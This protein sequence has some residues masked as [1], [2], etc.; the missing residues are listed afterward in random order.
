METINLK[1]NT[2]TLKSVKEPANPIPAIK[3]LRNI[4]GLG[5]KEAKDVVDNLRCMN[6]AYQDFTFA[7]RDEDIQKLEVYFEIRIKPEVK[8]ESDNKVQAHWHLM[9]YAAELLDQGNFVGAGSVCNIMS[10]LKTVENY[11]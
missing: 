5:L 11:E 7:V 8:P 6:G 1:M 2:V 9:N 3:E 10:I 4:S